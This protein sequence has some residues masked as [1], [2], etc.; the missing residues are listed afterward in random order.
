M[1]SWERLAHLT[2]KGCGHKTHDSPSYVD[3]AFRPRVC[4]KC[5]ES[6][7]W[8]VFAYTVRHVYAGIWWKPWTWCLFHETRKHE[9]V[10]KDRPDIRDVQ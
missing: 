4:P 7:G 2:C 6:E 3:E 1:N 9:E 5:G 8:T 10:M